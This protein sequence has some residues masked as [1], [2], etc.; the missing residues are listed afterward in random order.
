LTAL[1]THSGDA[2]RQAVEE[3]GRIGYG[4]ARGALI[5][6]LEHSDPRT[7]AA[8][9]GALAALHDVTA[10]TVLLKAMETDARELR[11]AAIQALGT[12]GTAAAV[13][14]LLGFVAGRRLDAET[15]QGIRDAVAAIQSRLAG[16]E[17]G[18]LSLAATPP[19]S[20]WL[21]VAAPDDG[22]GRLSLLPDRR[23]PGS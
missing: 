15:R 6:L 16:A 14:P 11:R 13:E 5:V 22:H 3:L 8:A 4:R 9:A 19:G 1:K 2:R 20:G 21:S 7:A 18:Q 17:A 10:E 12:V 23:R